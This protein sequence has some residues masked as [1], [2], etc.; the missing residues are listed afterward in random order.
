M[1]QSP[2]SS[3]P[4]NPQNV[5]SIPKVSMGRNFRVYAKTHTQKT[6][7][8]P[9]PS[10][11]YTQRLEH[12]PGRLEPRLAGLPSASAQQLFFLAFATVRS[13]PWAVRPR[14]LNSR[15][16][17]HDA[18]PMFGKRPPGPS[19]VSPSS[20]SSR[21]VSQ[22]GATPPTFQHRVNLV[23]ESCGAFGRAFGCPAV[24]HSCGQDGFSR[25]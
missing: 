19:Q 11:V 7:E 23:L 14:N 9:C 20:P 2:R 13:L 6:W 12:P 10:Q 5:G 21:S 15:R 3:S 8:I 16:A 4:Q 18:G 25:G 24:R 22:I 17:N 1:R